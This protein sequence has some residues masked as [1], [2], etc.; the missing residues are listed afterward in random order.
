MVDTWCVGGIMWECCVYCGTDPADAA[1]H[2]HNTPLITSLATTH[3]VHLAAHLNIPAFRY[4]I[5][6]CTGTF[7]KDFFSQGAVI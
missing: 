1:I 6:D 3:R 2:H 4:S 5:I 7:S